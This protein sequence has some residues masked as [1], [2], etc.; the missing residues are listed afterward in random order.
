MAAKDTSALLLSFFV[1]ESFLF[2]SG[3]NVLSLQ[4]ISLNGLFAF[5]CDVRVIDEL[6]FFSLS[7]AGVLRDRWP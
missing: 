6:G 3:V 7:F 1:E 5:L 2:Q 4:L